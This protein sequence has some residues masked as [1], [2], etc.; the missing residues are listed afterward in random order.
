MNTFK[1]TG[2]YPINDLRALVPTARAAA[3]AATK[4][5]VKR[6][7]PVRIVETWR[8]SKRQHQL[9][10][11]G[12]SKLDAGH[13]T[14]EFWISLDVCANIKG[15]PYHKPTLRA[16]ASV[17]KSFGW[18]WGGDFKGFVDMPHFQFCT[19]SE[20]SKIRALKD[21]DAIENYLKARKK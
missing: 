14:H 12:K 8:P 18:T 10:L 6:K 1:D 5:C 21:Y 7:I 19:V 15:N 16:I 2:K 11:A 9:F 20:Q 13:G 17:F 4:E 3:I